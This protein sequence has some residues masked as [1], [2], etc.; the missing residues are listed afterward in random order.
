[1]SEARTRISKAIKELDRL[2]RKPGTP[3]DEVIRIR[4]KIEGLRLAQYYLHE[5]GTESNVIDMASRSS[6]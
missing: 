5:D 2:H 4:G 6:G 3:I 1:M